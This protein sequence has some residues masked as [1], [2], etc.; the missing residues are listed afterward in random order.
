MTNGRITFRWRDYAHENQS[1]TMTVDADEFLRRF[2]L[3]V[4]PPS[5]VRIRYFG[6]FANRQ[7]KLSLNLCRE[8]LQVSVPPQ[9]TPGVANLCQHCHRGIM[10]LLEVL[11]PARLSIWLAEAPQPENSS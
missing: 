1:Q 6:M 8:Y 9:V 11:S 7:R 2:L 5:F 10:R 4:L 3:H